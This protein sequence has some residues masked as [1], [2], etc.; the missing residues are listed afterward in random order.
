MST[1]RRNAFLAVVAL[2]AL[3]PLA[4]IGWNEVAL[5]RGTNVVLRTV[6]VDPVDLFRGRYVELRYAI[7]SLPT[8][9]PT[10]TTIYV[11]LAEADDVWSGNRATTERPADGVSIRGRVVGPDRIVYGIETYYADEDEAQRL[12][13]EAG[14]RLL[15]HVS[16]EP[17]GQA[18]IDKVE[19]R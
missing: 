7:S 12:E 11:P 17:D 3:L 10:G 13:R 14:D 8:N 9:A 5:A 19:V 15:V 18:R 4:L 6:P 2:Q 1:R 16:I